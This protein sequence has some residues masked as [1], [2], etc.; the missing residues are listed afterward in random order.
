MNYNT[1]GGVQADIAPRLRK[2]SEGV[3]PPTSAVSYTNITTY[4]PETSL[5]SNV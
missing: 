3:Y 1:I 4:S 5:P 2:E